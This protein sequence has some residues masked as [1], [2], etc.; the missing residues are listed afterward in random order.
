MPAL[1]RMGAFWALVHSPD[2]EVALAGSDEV[3]IILRSIL[4]VLNCANVPARCLGSARYL[5][6]QEY[7]NDIFSGWGHN[8]W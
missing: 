8:L 2:I 7:Y 6:P 4:L 3:Y 1:D 5:V